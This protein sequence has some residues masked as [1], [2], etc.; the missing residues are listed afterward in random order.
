MSH[1]DVHNARPSLGRTSPKHSPRDKTISS[2]ADIETRFPRIKKGWLDSLADKNSFELRN[3]RKAHVDAFEFD[4]SDAIQL[5]LDL[6]SSDTSSTVIDAAKTWLRTCFEDVVGNF[7]SN[8]LELEELRDDREL[9]VRSEVDGLFQAMQTRHLGNLTRICAS[10][11]IALQNSDERLSADV[12][13]LQKRSKSLALANM[14]TE[15]RAAFGE[16]QSLSERERESRAQDIERAFAR[17]LA[18]AADAQTADIAALEAKLSAMLADIRSTIDQEIKEME[19]RGICAL[20]FH[21]RKAIED[22][23]TATE[24]PAKRQEITAD[25]VQFLDKLIRAQDVPNFLPAL[26]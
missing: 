8:S 7:Q 21:L 1:P 2:I 18:T 3:L 26:G 13:N 25:L 24:S 4:E 12:R 20:R 10:R 23:L 16:A 22:V 6:R 15:A 14:G 9:Q 5:L 11:R 19:N 17:Q